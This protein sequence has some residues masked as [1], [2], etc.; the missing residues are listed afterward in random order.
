MFSAIER[1]RTELNPS[2]NF[3]CQAAPVAESA[4]FIEWTLRSETT[5]GRHVL[6]CGPASSGKTSMAYRICSR[7]FRGP[8]TVFSYRLDCRTL[9]GKEDVLERTFLN[10]DCSQEKMWNL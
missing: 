4:R 6:L 9:R 3:S 1:I 7:L 10:L 8:A 5:V 2:G